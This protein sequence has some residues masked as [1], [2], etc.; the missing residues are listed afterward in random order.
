MCI[1]VDD[2]KMLVEPAC[3]AA[4]TAVYS[5]IIGKLQKEGKLSPNLSSLVIIVCGG[6]NITLAQLFHLKEQLDIKSISAAWHGCL[7]TRSR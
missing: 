3:G 4:L 5:N 1:R 2:E 7:K 6:N